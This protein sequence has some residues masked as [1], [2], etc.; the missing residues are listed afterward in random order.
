MPT[1][2]MNILNY[3]LEHECGNLIKN[4][5]NA[6]NLLDAYHFTCRLPTIL[7]ENEFDLSETKINKIFCAQWLDDRSVILGT[8]CNKVCFL[9]IFFL[10]SFIF[11]IIFKFF[12]LVGYFR[13]N[14]T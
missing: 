9:L 14:F 8:K 12:V 5:K 10:K 1:Y 3:T 2:A 13:H 6:K 7:K 4:K 11:T